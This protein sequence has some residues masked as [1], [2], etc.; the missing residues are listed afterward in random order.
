MWLDQ[1]D[2]YIDVRTHG[3]LLNGIADDTDAFLRAVTAANN[4]CG[5]VFIPP[6][7]VTHPNGGLNITPV[8]LTARRLTIFGVN[9]SGFNS[10]TYSKVSRI[11]LKAGS[12]DSLITLL[13]DGGT[14]AQNLR[15]EGLMLDGQKA[16]QGAITSHG[17]YLPT[18]ATGED[19]FVEIDR[20]YIASFVSDCINSEYGRR[21]TKVTNTKM[22]QSRNGWLCSSS[23]GWMDK[24]DIGQMSQDGIQ[25]HDWTMAITANNIFSCRNGIN[26]FAGEASITSIVGNR[27]DR[28]QFCG[29]RAQG[30]YAAIMGNVFHRNSESGL[31][32]AA[33]IN[34]GGTY[35]TI[36]G[37]TFRNGNGGGFPA[38]YDVYL[39]ADVEA[40]VGLNA[41]DGRGNANAYGHIG[42]SA[43]SRVRMSYGEYDQSPRSYVQETFASAALTAY[44]LPANAF[45]NEVIRRTGSPASGVTD[46]TDT[47]TNIVADIGLPYSILNNSIGSAIRFR[48]INQTGQTIT[49]AGGTG[50]TMSGTATVANNTWRDFVLNINSGTA[51]TITNLGSGAL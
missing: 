18:V 1:S 45:R 37:N 10:G 50:V 22:W 41:T 12:T 3:A 11:M 36:S 13:G 49:I 28:H 34:V 14:S 48:Y 51:V 29:I 4:G 39:E 8:Q 31:A 24:C 23:D 7:P 44:A 46:T 25:V 21:A 6:P 40:A 26:L 2:E 30:G 47:A 27:I 42:R 9:S 35:T 38:S 43:G 16:L 5:K 15:I 32:A 19:S 17:V 33:H 20:C